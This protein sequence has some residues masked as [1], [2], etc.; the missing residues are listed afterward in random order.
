MSNTEP[1]K[2]DAIKLFQDLEHHFPS[3]TL[4]DDKWQILAIAAVTGGGH[5]EHAATLYEY[6]I[7]KTQYGTSDS[8]KAL[9]RR[10]REALVKLVSVVGVPK[11]LEAVFCIGEIE[12]GEDRD[13]SFSR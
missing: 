5:P 6:L 8:R 4:G 11:P 9:I 7:L 1:S 3:K 2:G 10:L 13:Y 12:R